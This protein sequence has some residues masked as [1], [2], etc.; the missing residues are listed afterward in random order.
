MDENRIRRPKGG[1]KTHQYVK[2]LD[3]QSKSR[4]A[5]KYQWN[6]PAQTANKDEERNPKDFP[7]ISYPDIYS[8]I[9]HDKGA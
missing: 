6:Q 8:C 3:V 2:V 7:H 5:R 9:S 4:Y 1:K